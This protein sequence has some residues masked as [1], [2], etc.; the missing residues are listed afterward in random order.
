MWEASDLPGRC[1]L[2][3]PYTLSDDK[4]ETW[5]YPAVPARRLALWVLGSAPSPISR[6]HNNFYQKAYKTHVLDALEI[7]IIYWLF[8]SPMGKTFKEWPG[9]TVTCLSEMIILHRE[10]EYR[11]PKASKEKWS[12]CHLAWW[13]LITCHIAAVIILALRYKNL[14]DSQQVEENVQH[15]GWTTLQ[16]TKF[17]LLPF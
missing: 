2:L 10:G 9:V 13:L 14:S 4:V 1:H 16:L 15:N 11:C 8:S 6:S 17:K 5:H 3:P 12:Y 7:L